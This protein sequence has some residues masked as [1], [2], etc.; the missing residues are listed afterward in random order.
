MSDIPDDAAQAARMAQDAERLVEVLQ[1]EVA[2]AQ[3]A[4]DAAIERREA[5][6]REWLTP[7]TPLT[8]APQGE[9]RAR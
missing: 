1:Q 6:Y 9:G 7:A 8:D 4:L 5:I 2:A 3:V